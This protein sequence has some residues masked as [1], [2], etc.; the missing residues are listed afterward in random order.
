MIEI[1]PWRKLGRERIAQSNNYK[2]REKL[3]ENTEAIQHYNNC[4]NH[5]KIAKRQN[6]IMRH[7]TRHISCLG[8]PAYK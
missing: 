1:G 2:K 6:T 8:S 5:Q 3:V 7:D 4:K